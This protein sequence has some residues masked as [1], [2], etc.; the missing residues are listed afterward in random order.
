M[1][2]ANFKPKI[3]AMASRGFL[4]AARLSRCKLLQML[5][6][7]IRRAIGPFSFSVSIAFYSITSILT[8]PI[9]YLSLA[10]TCSS[11]SHEWPVLLTTNRFQNNFPSVIRLGRNKRLTS[12]RG[13]RSVGAGHRTPSVKFNS[14][15]SQN[16]TQLN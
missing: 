12:V 9:S 13:R 5:A 16:E 3:T 1:S 6:L 2:L 15:T 10:C 8:F 11:S 4:A 14:A 7:F